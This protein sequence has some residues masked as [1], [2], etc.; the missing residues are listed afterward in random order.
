MVSGDLDAH[1]VA[2]DYRGFGDSTN[3]SP[4]IPRVVEDSDA[5]YR[6]LLEKVQPKSRV[7][8]WGH[9][10]GSGVAVQLAHKYADTLFSP[11]AVIL[12]STFTNME[13]AVN[14]FPFSAL[15]RFW[16]CFENLVSKVAGYH[17]DT[18]ISNDDKMAVAVAS[19][20]LI[21]HSEDDMFLKV[22]LARKMYRLGHQ[23]VDKSMVNARKGILL[24]KLFRPHYVEFEA[25]LGYGHKAFTDPRVP[26]KFADFLDDIRRQNNA[27]LF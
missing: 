8:L 10:L 7:I 18:Y 5:V 20:I 16:P 9:S 25:H 26:E 2:F 24:P 6:W 3:E 12:E 27:T 13:D 4:T 17:P 14:S 23:A 11:A 1:V 19:P 15:H 21:L 22:D